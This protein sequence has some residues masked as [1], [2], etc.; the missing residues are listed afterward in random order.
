MID[1]HSE[2]AQEIVRAVLTNLHGRKGIGNE[3]E[4]IDGYVYNDMQ[5]KLTDD[6]VDPILR[7]H[8][9]DVLHF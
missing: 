1:K 7:K 4:E 3:L 9:P 5:R 2:V 6:I 8:F